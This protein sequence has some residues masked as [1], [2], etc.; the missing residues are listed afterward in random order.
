M[1]CPNCGTQLRDNALFCTN[2]GAPVSRVN[3]PAGVQ[4]PA[5]TP[6]QNT[7]S[8]QPKV[9]PPAPNHAPVKTTAAA[10]AQSVKA[11]AAQAPVNAPAVA[12]AQQTVNTAQQNNAAPAKTVFPAKPA[13]AAPAKTVFP[14]AP[15][16]NSASEPFRVQI[17]PADDISAGYVENSVSTASEKAVAGADTAAAANTADPS[18]AQDSFGSGDFAAQ[19]PNYSYNPG[20]AVPKKPPVDVNAITENAKKSFSGILETLRSD[21]KA[22]YSLLILA[23]LVL[24]FA[25]MYAAK[26]NVKAYGITAGSMSV[27][28]A[29]FSAGFG[30]V[31]VLS[32]LFYIFSILLIAVPPMLKLPTRSLYFYAPLAASGFTLLWFIIINVISSFSRGL[33]GTRASLSF[34]GWLFILIAGATVAFSIVA[35]VQLRKEE[36][37]Q[38]TGNAVS[39]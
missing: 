1:F 19:T 2:C 18:A 17:D 39:K 31:V 23:L 3:K 27:R 5:K 20:T 10:P 36:N 7:A 37:A 32:I 34:G 24:G 13:D 12:A 14:A 38:A 25:F 22:M 15:A 28:D 29:V 6:Y 4:P 35:A 30:F 26:L 21:K 33:L 11:P 16:D 9:N 8:A